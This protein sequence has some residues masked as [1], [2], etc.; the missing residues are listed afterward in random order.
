MTLLLGGCSCGSN[1]KEDPLAAIPAQ[2]VGVRESVA[3]APSW[4]TNKLSPEL[5]HGA[6]LLPLLSVKRDVDA[7]K[8]GALVCQ[9]QLSRS[10]QWDEV[11]GGAK[12]LGFRFGTPSSPAPD[13][14]VIMA[15]GPLPEVT[16][17]GPEDTYD[18]VYALPRPCLVKGDTITIRVWDV[19]SGEDQLAGAVKMVVDTLPVQAKLEAGQVICGGLSQE[20]ARAHASLSFA[21]FDRL[22]AVAAGGFT[23][24][25]GDENWG[26][27]RNLGMQVPLSGAAAML[28]WADPEV[29]RRQE[30]FSKLDDA[31]QVAVAHSMRETQERLPAPETWISLAPKPIDVRVGVMTCKASALFGRMKSVACEATLDVR[32]KGSKP[33]E[34]Q[35]ALTDL[36]WVNQ[37]GGDAGSPDVKLPPGRDA[38]AENPTLPP[39]QSIQLTLQVYPGTVASKT[40]PIFLK[41]R[42]ERGVPTLVRVF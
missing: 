40:Q 19:D 1:D 4:A 30:V 7:I 39:G 31:W 12:V 14:G 27:P 8:D 32:N 24:K 2:C 13:I 10:K 22:P 3:N 20:L 36:V 42:S 16:V 29:K 41:F 26:Y 34:L 33:L 15:A 25:P 5:N 17:I 28:G 37:R 23:P 6:K 11:G 38:G 21:E 18:L 35:E 9:V